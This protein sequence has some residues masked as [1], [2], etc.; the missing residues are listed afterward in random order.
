MKRDWRS[1]VS[2]LTIFMAACGGGS[3]GSTEA[4]APAP[5]ATSVKDALSTMESAGTTPALD[6]TASRTGTDTNANGV[7][8]DVEKYID[9]LPDTAPQ[10]KSLASLSKAMSAALGSTPNDQAS[11]RAATAQMNNSVAC[12]WK[13]YPPDVADQKVQEM[14]KVT[15]N[16]RGRYDAYAAYNAAVA[17]T[18]I[19]LPRE[20]ACD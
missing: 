11:L 8:D 12:V 1:G 20:V 3:G 4:P 6:R 16:T 13:S 19:K 2:T 14:R 15:V 9:S 18:V 10:K 5:Q 7:R 17:G